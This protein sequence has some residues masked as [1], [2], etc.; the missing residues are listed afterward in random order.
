MEVKELVRGVITGAIISL[1]LF[2]VVY[3]YGVYLPAEVSAANDTRVVQGIITGSMVTIFG[4][5][6]ATIVLGGRNNDDFRN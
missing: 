3:F 5:I 1:L 6:L 2:C 4:L